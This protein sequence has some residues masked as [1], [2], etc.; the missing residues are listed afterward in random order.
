MPPPISKTLTPALLYFVQSEFQLDWFGIHGA[1]HWA[2]VRY[3]G[4]TLA[5]QTGANPRIV[6]LF[7]FLHDVRREHDG[8]DRH[9]GAR[10]AELAGELNGRVFSLDRR[11]FGLLEQACREHSDG[12]TRADITVQ[13]CWDADRL[14]LGR[15]GIRPSPRH[16]CTE[17]ARDKAMLASAYAR[18]VRRLR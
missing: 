5:R 15:V 10:A 1:G 3:N 6:E 17:A 18:S 12:H 9:H 2:R 8:H 11:E 13:T 7:A 16:L 4:L 14:D